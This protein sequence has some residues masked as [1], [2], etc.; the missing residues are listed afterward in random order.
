MR[1]PVS[2]TAEELLAVLAKARER[3]L[4]DWVI[5]L[6][7]YWHAFR[8]SE[9][10]L[11]STRQ[12]GLFYTREKA[13]LR[14][15][16]VGPGSE[17]REVQ[18]RIC[19]KLRHCYL[20]TSADPLRRSG[21]TADAI[22]GQEITQQRLKRSE[23]TTQQLFEHDNPLLNER[24]AWREW[25]AQRESLGKKGGAKRPK[26]S[27]AK[28]QQNNILL[29]NPQPEP[30]SPLFSISRSQVFRIFQRC[31]AEAGLPRRKRHPHVLKH[32]ILTQL[33]ESGM[34]LPQVQVHAGHRSLAS[35][36]RYT[37]ASED[38]VSQAVG[39]AISSRQEFR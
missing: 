17:V 11:S 4:R 9:V 29:Q 23:E 3:R 14:C 18:R 10:V 20:V 25:M 34:P 15:A 16:E 2:L 1:A 38:A 5:L 30:D 33:T 21:L 6:T 26:S 35:T 39:R 24:L 37:L 36:G 7:T 27:R 22:E 8:V 13:E 12:R 19:G 28:M 31:A 32:T